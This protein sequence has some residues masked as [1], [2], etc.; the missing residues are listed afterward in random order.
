MKKILNLLGTITLIG[1]STTNLVAC[2]NN[3]IHEYT[4]EQLE[5]LKEENKINTK[6]EY[7]KN[8]LEWISPQEKP[9]NKVDNKYYFVV[10]H[11]KNNDD[12]RIIKFKNDIDI[13]YYKKRILDKYNTYDLK[14]TEENLLADENRFAHHF[15]WDVDDG[16]HFKAVYRWNLDIDIPDLDVNNKTGEIKIK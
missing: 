2:D 14:M 16:S 10:W 3:K 12:W 4:K 15:W 5:K 11:I 6:D 13:G 8:N 7:I 9:F 1:A